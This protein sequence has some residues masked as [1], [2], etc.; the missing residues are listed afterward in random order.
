MNQH[1][2]DQDSDAST[3][4][5]DDRNGIRRRSHRLRGIPPHNATQPASAN[6]LAQQQPP[7]VQLVSPAIQVLQ[8]HQP[9]PNITTAPEQPVQYQPA[10]IQQPLPH[11]QAQGALAQHAAAAASQPPIQEV[12]LHQPGQPRELRRIPRR[13][14]PANHPIQGQPPLPQMYHQQNQSFQGYDADGY[15]S[16]PFID[17]RS[18]P[19]Q[20]TSSLP[21]PLHNPNPFDHINRDVAMF[22]N[23]LLAIGNTVDSLVQQ[24]TESHE[25]NRRVDAQLARIDETNNRI[26]QQ[27]QSNQGE[28]R[29][30]VR[31]DLGIVI[32]SQITNFMQS[33]QRPP[34]PSSHGTSVYVEQEQPATAPTSQVNAPPAAALPVARPPPPPPRPSPQPAT[35]APAPSSAQQVLTSVQNPTSSDSSLASTATTANTIDLPSLIKGIAKAVQPKEKLLLPKLQKSHKSAYISWRKETMLTIKLHPSF[36]KYVEKSIS[37]GTYLIESLPTDLRGT[38]YMSLSK[39]LDNSVKS[40][41]G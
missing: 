10:Q 8:P 38:L 31:E 12:Q 4:Y 28:F 32:A 36:S 25:V 24:S 35:T 1:L 9:Q 14:F 27:M 37:R 29:R 2:S 16:Q 21:V 20:G 40:D 19:E 17:D 18:F 3:V 22:Q 23:R 34:T 41:I 13:I 11:L 15:D 30:F 6:A 7:Q 5:D 39:A 33:Q 26:S